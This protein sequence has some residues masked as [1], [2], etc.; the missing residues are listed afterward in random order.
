MRTAILAFPVLAVPEGIKIISM[1]SVARAGGKVE[2]S[3]NL[4]P[5]APGTALY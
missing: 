2:D 1:H 4:F 3:A 5:S